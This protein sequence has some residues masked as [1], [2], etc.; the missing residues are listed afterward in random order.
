MSSF[1]RF[2]AHTC[3]CNQLAG[4][5]SLRSHSEQLVSHF[6]LAH[7][8]PVIFPSVSAIPFLS[9]VFFVFLCASLFVA[10]IWSSQIDDDTYLFP[11]NLQVHLANYDPKEMLFLGRVLFP[12]GLRMA[13]GGAGYLISHALM[14]QFVAVMPQCMAS[15][16]AEED[17]RMA[18][19]MNTL[20]NVTVTNFPA[21]HPVLPRRVMNWR[22][23]DPLNPAW[24]ALRPVT[25]HGA[26]DIEQFEV[27]Y[28]LYE[29]HT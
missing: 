14:K 5:L 1:Q 22:G 8:H 15:H 3:V 29:A 23:W 13:S 19:C 28:L 11:H 25:F 12:Q 16:I 6:T 20:L 17:V 10:A 7:F 4:L 2:P 26:S 27:D 18:H 9:F 21:L 24:Y